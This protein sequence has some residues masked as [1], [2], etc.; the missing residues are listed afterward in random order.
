[1]ALECRDF[2]GSQRPKAASRQSAQLERSKPN[3]RQFQD[4]MAQRFKHPPNLPVTPLVNG[5]VE[6]A[7]FP[8]Y[9]DDSYFGP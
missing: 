5:Y 6:N 4:A 3:A 1:M 8:A 9:A 7:G 2:L